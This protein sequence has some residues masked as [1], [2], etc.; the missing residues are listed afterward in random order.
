MI[1]TE[2]IEQYGTFVARFDPCSEAELKPEMLAHVG[3]VLTFH[4]LWLIQPEDNKTHPN[5]W[6]CHPDISMADFPAA[7]VS[8]A[9]LTLVD[10]AWGVA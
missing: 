4:V 1:P 3:R 2:D 9:D 5:T 6:A 8:S 10:P 7:W